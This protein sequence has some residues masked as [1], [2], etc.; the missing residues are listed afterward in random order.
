MALGLQWDRCANMAEITSRIGAPNASLYDTDY[1]H[2]FHSKISP[3]AR[4][5]SFVTVTTKTPDA[6]NLVEGRLPPRPARNGF[7]EDN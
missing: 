3:N 1:Q 6:G 4:A 7:V 5:F 2:R